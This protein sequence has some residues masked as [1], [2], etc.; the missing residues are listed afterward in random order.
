M[1]LAWG[2]IEDAVKGKRPQPAQSTVKLAK[3]IGANGKSR[4]TSSRN[5][6]GGAAGASAAATVDARAPPPAHG[7]NA[8]E[9]IRPAPLSSSSA[10]SSHPRSAAPPQMEPRS[11]GKTRSR[12]RAG[13]DDSDGG[14][15]FGSRGN[16]GR[17]GGAEDSDNDIDDGS[18]GDTGAAVD[19]IGARLSGSGS[20]ASGLRFDD[21]DDD[22]RN[23][24]IGID[25]GA[26]FSIAG[27]AA[28]VDA[29]GGS[30]A[31]TKLTFL[32]QVGDDHP[33]AA[34]SSSSSM[35][36]PAPVAPGSA[37]SSQTVHGGAGASSSAATACAA[38]TVHHPKQQNND[39]KGGKGTKRQR[40]LAS[41]F[42]A[43]SKSN[44]GA[45]DADAG[46]MG[47]S[48]SSSSA[49]AAIFDSEDQH[50]DDDDGGA[51]DGH[52]DESANDGSAHGD[53]RRQRHDEG[54]DN[55][56]T[57]R[58]LTGADVG[59]QLGGASSS[60]AVAGSSAFGKPSTS[61][62][63][64]DHGLTAA[65]LQLRRASSNDSAVSAASNLHS[66][67]VVGRLFAS[68]VMP[69]QFAAAAS[70]AAGAEF[71]AVRQR[72]RLDSDGGIGAGAGSSAFSS[73][74]NSQFQSSQQQQQRL[75][76]GA[77]PRL[78]LRTTSLF[79]GS[80]SQQH[81]QATQSQSLDQQSSSEMNLDMGDAACYS[82]MSV[83]TID[84][85]GRREPSPTGYGPDGL[86]SHPPRFRLSEHDCL[87]VLKHVGSA[88]AFMHSR[89]L[90]H[91]DVKP[92]NILV[93][94]ESGPGMCDRDGEW[95]PEVC[96][97]TGIPSIDEE[98]LRRVDVL[99][100]GGILPDDVETGAAG[101]GAAAVGG[102]DTDMDGAGAGA[103]SAS[104]SS[105]S[106]A[107]GAGAA[108]SGSAFPAAPSLPSHATLKELNRD[109]LSRIGKLCYKLGDMGLAVPITARHPVEGDS[110]YLSREL[111]NGDT[112]LLTASDIFSLGLS[113]YELAS[114]IPLPTEGEE[115]AYFRDYPLPRD[116]VP[117]LPDDLY[118]LLC[119]MVHV[120]PAARP[121][122]HDILQIPVVE[123]CDLERMRGLLQHCQATGYFA[124]PAAT[125]AAAVTSA[126][127]TYAS[128]AQAGLPTGRILPQAGAAAAGDVNAHGSDGSGSAGASIG[129][130]FVPINGVGMSQFRVQRASGNT[131]AGDA[132]TQAGIS[133]QRQSLH[134]TP[135]SASTAG[136]DDDVDRQSDNNF[137]SDS[138]TSPELE[139]PAAHGH[140][141]AHPHNSNTRPLSVRT[142]VSVATAA[143]GASDP[144]ANINSGN[145]VNSSAGM[146]DKGLEALI[147]QRAAELVEAGVQQRLAELLHQVG[148]AATT[149]S[150]SSASAHQQLHSS[151]AA[152]ASGSNP[153]ASTYSS[154]PM[155]ISRM[156]DS[157]V[158][159][160]VPAAAVSG[161]VAHKGGKAGAS[162]NAASS[163][164]V[165]ARAAAPGPGPMKTPAGSSVIDLLSPN[166]APISRS[167]AGVAAH[168]GRSRSSAPATAAV[169]TDVTS[170]DG[171]VPFRSRAGHGASAAALPHHS[172]ID[173]SS[174]DGPLTLGDLKTAREAAAAVH[175]S[176]TAAINV[177]AGSGGR[178]A[179]DGEMAVDDD[180]ATTPVAMAP[181]AVSASAS[182]F[183]TSAAAASSSSTSSS[184][185]ALQVL[186]QQL[187]LRPEQVALLQTASKMMMA[188][189]APS[190]SLGFVQQ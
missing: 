90:A 86:H 2:S 146:S 120:D 75:L 185:S 82:Q 181:G 81:R 41:A 23:D 162:S 175:A 184:V 3:A 177:K 1:E 123:C 183:G 188:Q 135:G 70:S 114:G 92:A 153:L 131:G 100:A 98:V 144:N 4:T 160:A 34:A 62:I 118:N 59:F 83:F 124:A 60:S 45:S 89:G 151:S 132:R 139:L 173:I 57:A 104:S 80:Q 71:P 169:A 187:N 138:V 91:L 58:L 182:S 18:D 103:G 63:G 125:A 170:P 7:M 134:Q 42:K 19:I 17:R 15:G 130:D 77:L 155:G 164:S 85:G 56:N 61:G 22:M 88:L 145:V 68:Q 148:L 129:L 37:P 10:S 53:A 158:Q 115:Y 122:A 38:T 119:L 28:D 165:T 157:R 113:I 178:V 51:D 11:R 64:L 13:T 117:Q 9:G 84:Q 93:S 12:L 74:S 95:L 97:L 21:A 65:S 190:T 78:G 55:V 152:S 112:S 166:G 14:M 76:P 33:S 16:G 171:P 32:S 108:P 107:A 44:P 99:Q 101:A 20:I 72:L 154:D 121:T 52:N 167:F 43:K 143:S 111:L 127:G 69:S 109:R 140:F 50:D 67:P 102:V 36:L 26:G 96:S 30:G 186:L 39:N 116:A 189:S 141:G 128:P 149:S 27:P 180:D 147:A 156:S 106:A 142:G 46:A 105:S 8:G 73:A 163:S 174:P 40:T 137:G 48:S 136:L 6:A 110:R 66:Q 159:P 79:E 87:L 49:A 176:S 29:A 150:S 35:L 25:N 54:G 172:D 126:V 133:Q 31:A 161:N 24:N 47:A 168:A 5:A 94:Y 179:L